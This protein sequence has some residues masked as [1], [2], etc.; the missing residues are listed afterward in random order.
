MY[1]VGPR[2]ESNDEVFRR[3]EPYESCLR[4]EFGIED[5]RA[6]LD[7]GSNHFAGIELRED[8]KNRENWANIADWF[9]ES[10]VAYRRILTGTADQ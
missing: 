1:V 10:L 9:H 6:T 2:G 8:P 3:L 5:F 4:E 7:A